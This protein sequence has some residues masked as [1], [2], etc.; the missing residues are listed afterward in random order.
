MNEAYTTGRTAQQAI[1][2]L[3]NIVSQGETEPIID[4]YER[5]AW[6]SGASQIDTQN[7]IKCARDLFLAL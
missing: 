1:S 6:M 2:A 7:I 4:M 3:Y 5:A